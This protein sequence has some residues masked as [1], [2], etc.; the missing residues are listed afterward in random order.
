M[1]RTLTTLGILIAIALPLLDVALFRPGRRAL[2]KSRL[3]KIERLI[4]L[5]FLVSLLLQAISSF[6]MILVG[7]RMHGWMLVLHMSVAGLFA[8]TLTVLAVLWAEQSSFERGGEPRFYTGEKVAF[9]LILLTGL[10]TIATAMLGMMSWFGSV[11]QVML[12]RVHRYSALLL[13]I[14]AVFHGYRLLAGRPAQRAG[15]AEPVAAG[16]IS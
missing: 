9:W 15:M 10:A 7:Q 12:L 5:F 14:C 2:A 8:V 13:L 3:L 11:G 1:L 4:Y 16:G 6:G